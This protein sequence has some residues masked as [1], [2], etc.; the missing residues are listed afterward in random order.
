MLALP[1]IVIKVCTLQ[2]LYTFDYGYHGVNWEWK[3]SYNEELA[4]T[5]GEHKID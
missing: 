4:M 5:N 2:Q 1:Y 3:K